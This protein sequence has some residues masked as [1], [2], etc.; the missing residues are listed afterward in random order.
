MK[1][2]ITML[3]L[4][5]DVGY[6]RTLPVYEYKTQD[7]NKYAGRQTNEAPASFFISSLASGG[8]LFG[9]FMVFASYECLF[10]PIQ[11]V[12]GLTTIEYYKS[13]IKEKVSK[14]AEANPVIADIIEREY[15]GSL[16]EY[17][18]ESVRIFPVGDSE[19]VSSIG[20]C[21]VSALEEIVENEKDYGNS[22]YIDFT[23]GSRTSSMLLIMMARLFEAINADVRQVVYASIFNNHPEIQD[24]TDIYKTLT[25]LEDIAK[26]DSGANILK[27]LRKLEIT[28]DDSFLKALTDSEE[29]RRNL[30]E[31]YTG[32]PKS[33]NFEIDLSH[34]DGLTKALFKK[35]KERDK[36]TAA[37][38]PY[39][40][41]IERPDTALIKDFHSSI[42]A[43]LGEAGVIVVKDQRELAAND[44]YYSGIEKPKRNGVIPAV[45]SWLVHLKENTAL[46]PQSYWFDQSR[47]RVLGEDE[48]EYPYF[49]MK[50]SRR[51][52]DDF[53]RFLK[54]IKPFKDPFEDD[55]DLVADFTK[56]QT[57]YFNYGFPYA[58]TGVSNDAREY[59]DISQYYK[60]LVKELMDFLSKLRKRD[61][62]AY[63]K[64][65]ENLTGSDAE[66]G[67]KIPYYLGCMTAGDRF[68]ESDAEKE[69]FLREFC[70]RLEI[71]RPYRNAVAHNLD[72]EYSDSK[73]QKAIAASIREWLE[74]YRNRFLTKAFEK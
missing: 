21:F 49:P 47:L 64:E 32:V 37:K 61:P 39:D 66:L 28:D 34:A 12:G 36:E 65:L 73:R 52:S 62:N 60:K 53:L 31:K 74:E 2:L 14:E 55:F 1:T 22:L 3:S 72:N 19:D 43:V 51:M 40:K 44:A 57:V 20:K 24:I 54:I 8:E 7:G 56:I 27:N 42:M 46:D 38:S 45:K 16:D 26:N 18:N 41:M 17:I 59:R 71:V 23:G 13:V 6:G 29:N 5:K 69:S 4:I 68:F 58:C 67:K 63:R 15:S 70:E 9:R 25:Y 33:E 50:I 30:S 10:D 11:C 48:W 35:Q